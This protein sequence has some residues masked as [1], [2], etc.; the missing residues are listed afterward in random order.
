MTKIRTLQSI[1]ILAMALPTLAHAQDR[2]FKPTSKIYVAD[3]VGDVEIDTGTEIDDLTKRSV[4]NAEGTSI[5]TRPDS[6]A[7]LVFSNGTG[8]YFDV[9]TRVDIRQFEQASFRPN[10]ADIEDEPSISTTVLYVSHGVIGISASKMVAG[11]SLQVDTPLASAHVRGRQSVVHVTDSLVVISMVQGDATV[12]TKSDNA[13][14]II[15]A[16]QQILVRAG[17]AGEFS[18]VTI[19]SIN[20]GTSDDL[21]TW[22]DERLE[23]ADAARRLVYFEVQTVG[24]GTARSGSGSNGGSV[25]DSNPSDPASGTQIVPVPVVPVTPPVQPNVSPANLSGL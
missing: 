10:R 4:Y 6:N 25:F 24:S 22:L 2:K 23:T 17:R 8:V 14:Y 3:T 12:E 20:S 15:K 18:T 11:S 1:C 16:G 7:S 9:D 19:Q 13:S 5:H 21:S